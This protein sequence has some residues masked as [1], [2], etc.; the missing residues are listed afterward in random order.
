MSQEHKLYHN[1]ISL[2]TDRRPTDVVA[3]RHELVLLFDATKANPNGDPDTGNMPR[4]QPDTLKGLVTDVCLKRKIR[5]IFSLYRPDGTL[6][7]GGPPAA[8]G[9]EFA[10]Y[11][12]FIREN[13]V[14]RELMEAP[15]IEEQAKSIFVGE[16]KQDP[17][18]WDAKKRA[19][20]GRSRGGAA[21]VPP[22]EDA[23]EEAQEASPA[24]EFKK[25][26]YRDAL[27]RSFFDLR[28]FGGVISTDGPLKGSFYG[29]IRGPVQF[30]FAESLDRVLQLDA[31][32]T[33]CCVASEKEKKET[34]SAGAEETGH[35][36]MGRKHVVNYGLYRANVYFSP[37]FALRTGFTYYDLDNLLFAITHM[38]TDDAAAGRAGMRVVGLIDF[39][40]ATALGNEHAHKLFDLVRISRTSESREREFPSSLCDYEGTAP[41]G[42]VRHVSENG[43]SKSLVVARKL[44]WEIPECS[45]TGGTT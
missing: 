35:R 24:D 2:P 44:V 30:S 33:R 41:D 43:Q 34:D 21:S 31:T 42:V 18:S 19:R 29:Q 11:E 25:R 15:R 17:R 40:H 37:A 3:E 20:T 6:Q 14:L 1:L 26:A 4:L 39:Q 27:C 38:F 36:T 10:G 45:R 13:A 7:D 8:I 28:A 12:I 32:I 23:P 5:N 9:S 22:P 16:L